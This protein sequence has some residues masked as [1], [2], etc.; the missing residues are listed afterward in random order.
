LL[1]AY[2]EA[3]VPKISFILRKA[4]GGAYAVMSSRHLNG[5]T[6]YSYPSGEIAVMGA[7]GA[8]QLIYP[9]YRGQEPP[10]D[11]PEVKEY[12][13]LYNNPLQACEFGFIDDVVVPQKTREIIANDLEV[14]KT[15]K[16]RLPKRKHGNIPL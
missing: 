13:F 10:A 2:S 3:S 8:V 15:K 16:I 12:E 5:D 11:A 14:L 9:Q 6:N 7:K 1:Y 4:Y